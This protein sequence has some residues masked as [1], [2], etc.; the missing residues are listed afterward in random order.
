MI[1]TKLDGTQVAQEMDVFNRSKGSEW[2]WY[3]LVGK[4]WIRKSAYESLTK[5]S[6]F[7]LDM[8]DIKVAMS[9]PAVMPPVGSVYVYE[10]ET[11]NRFTVPNSELS[12]YGL[13]LT[14][15]SFGPFAIPTWGIIGGIGLLGLM[16]ILRR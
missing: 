11:G 7:S 10:I 12:K 8:S 16:L 15:I 4:S 5:L 2:V 1:E 9:Y 6:K 3:K 14:G 13:G